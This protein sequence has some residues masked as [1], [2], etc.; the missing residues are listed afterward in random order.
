M[1]GGRYPGTCHHAPTLPLHTLDGHSLIL[2]NALLALVVTC[3]LLVSRI[4]LGDGARGLRTWVAGDLAFAAARWSAMVELGNPQGGL[5][6][7]FPVGTGALGCMA[8]VWHFQA[9]RRL[10][11]HGPSPPWLLLQGLV[12]AVLFVAGALSLTGATQRLWLMDATLGLAAAATLRVVWPLR[13][14]WGGR[15]IAAMML[16]AV[17]FQTGRFVALALGLSVGEST[18]EGPNPRLAV[19]PLMIDLM[20]ALFVSAGFMLLLQER[21][22]ERIERLVVTDALTGVLNRHGLMAPLQREMASASRH[23]RPLSVALFDLDHFKRV[24]DEHGHAVGDQVLAGFAARVEAQRRGGDHVPVLDDFAAF[25]AEDV[26]DGIAGGARRRLRVHMQH[27]QVALHDHALDAAAAVG[28][29]GLQVG[30]K[31]RAASA[32]LRFSAAS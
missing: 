26:D 12:A 4:G 11:G 9:L 32:S 3:M 17:V 21:L 7:G 13:R 19:E 1:S 15:M 24:N 2:S 22:R 8:L 16:L 20:I 23:Q 14:L 18:V 25:D 27:H 5:G 10:Q 31:A 30:Q 6:L 29:L 28:R